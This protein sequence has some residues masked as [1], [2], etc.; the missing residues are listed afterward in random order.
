MFKLQGVRLQNT[1]QAMTYELKQRL[2][3]L[4]DRYEQADFLTGDPS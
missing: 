1:I 3:R 4:A 2:I